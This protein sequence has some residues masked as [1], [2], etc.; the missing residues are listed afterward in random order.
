MSDRMEHVDHTPTPRVTTTVEEPL[1]TTTTTYAGRVAREERMQE[2]TL[3]ELFV[4]LSDDFSHLV[5]QEMALAKAEM[6]E[7]LDRGRQGATLMAAGGVIAYSGL[8]V[9]LAAIV[10]IVGD[11]IDS[12]WL[13]ALG[14]GAVVVVVGLLLLFSGKGKLDEM[15][16][17]P[18]K[19]IN[20][21]ERDAKMA[22]EKLT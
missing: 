15:N 6:R 19:T 7:N 11:L 12:Y 3:G 20:S 9:I 8:L 22:K 2:P 21:I 17:I 18:K 10:L 4:E 1:R 5:R 14:V 13:A 16:L